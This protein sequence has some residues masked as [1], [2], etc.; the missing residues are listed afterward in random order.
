M[1]D[2]KDKYIALLE[3]QN[4]QLKDMLAK[5]VKIV[6]KGI[7]DPESGNVVGYYFGNRLFAT[8]R[9]ID[10]NDKKFKI[11]FSGYGVSIMCNSIS[12]LE[13]IIKEGVCG[14]ASSII[15]ETEEKGT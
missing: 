15:I 13:R 3:E 1:T 5:Q 8:A 6:L 10:K 12:D 4:E 11:D 14:N 7:G 9:C 2:P